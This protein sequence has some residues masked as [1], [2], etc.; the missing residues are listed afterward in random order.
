MP[1]HANWI[2]ELKMCNA[3][4]GRVILEKIVT[5]A[6]KTIMEIQ[7]FLVVCAL[8]ASV[9]TTLTLLN[10]EVVTEKLASVLSVFT[11]PL[12][13]IVKYVNQ[14]ITE[15]HLRDLVPSVYAMN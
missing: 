2:T 7:L 12:V 11:T 14:V 1:I 5:G 15:M 13:P 10:L 6:M 8:S 3:I 4:V 9:I